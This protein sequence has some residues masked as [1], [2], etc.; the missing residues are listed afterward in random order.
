M[1][2]WK[3]NGK[4]AR[5]NWWDILAGGKD[6]KE[7]VVAGRKFPILKTIRLRKGYPDIIRLLTTTSI[8]NLQF[9][10]E[11]VLNFES[12]ATCIY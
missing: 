10:N 6:G 11:Y 9:A 4:K 7:L 2:E 1:V 3:Q 12:S 5:R 8:L